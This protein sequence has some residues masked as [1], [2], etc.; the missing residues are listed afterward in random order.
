MLLKPRKKVFT[1][2]EIAAACQVSLSTVYRILRDP[3]KATNPIRLQVRGLL[4]Q[5]G[6]LQGFEHKGR[7]KILNV[8]LPGNYFHI[9]AMFFELEKVCVNRG[10]DLVLCNYHQLDSIL[11]TTDA[12]GLIYN[13]SVSDFPDM[14]LVVARPG[15][16]TAKCTSVAEDDVGGLTLLFAKLKEF[17]H[18]RI[19]YFSP[20]CFQAELCFPDRFLPEKARGF[21]T[22]NGLPY[23]ESLVCHRTITTETHEKVMKEVVNYYLSLKPRPTAVVVSGD[24]YAPPFY[25]HLRAAGLRIPEDVSIAGFDDMCRYRHFIDMKVDGAALS[26]VLKLTPPLTTMDLPLE[27][28]ASTAVDLLLE[29]IENPFARRRKVVL[30]PD[31]VI[32]NSITKVKGEKEK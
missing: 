22:L 28:I 21:Y 5:N 25:R 18:R 7:L 9:S 2:N 32:T 8:T 11:R 6:Y 4:I 10:I 26:E 15:Y 20:N 23:D 19:F 16:S 29:Q 27:D 3:E 30:Q 14:P 13:I 17:G 24:V 31:L 1:M 12:A